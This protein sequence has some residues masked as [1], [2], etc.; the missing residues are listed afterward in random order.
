MEYEIWT[1][2][3]RALRESRDLRQQD[4]ADMVPFSRSQYCAI[5]NGKCV[6]NYVHL[7]NLAKAFKM[8]LPAFLAMK[9]VRVSTKQKRRRLN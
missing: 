8:S 7:Y 6:A 3:L 9:G 2:K 4:V 5:E 1:Q